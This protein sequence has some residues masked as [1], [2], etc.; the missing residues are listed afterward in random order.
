MGKWSLYGTIFG[1]IALGVILTIIHEGVTPLIVDLLYIIFVIMMIVLILY[2]I[3]L[4]PHQW[5][6]LVS[7]IAFLS[8]IYYM[9]RSW[10]ITICLGLLIIVYYLVDKKVSHKRV[11]QTVRIILLAGFLISIIY[12]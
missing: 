7:L 8:L 12:F 11:S 9:K 6:P 4:F 2:I 1:V 3:S 10:Q 5:I